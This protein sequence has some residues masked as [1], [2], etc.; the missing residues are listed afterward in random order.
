[1]HDPI[2]MHNSHLLQCPAQK[3]ATPRSKNA[4]AQAAALSTCLGLVHAHN[5][6]VLA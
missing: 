6:T 1:M 5:H 3:N 4:T 2:D